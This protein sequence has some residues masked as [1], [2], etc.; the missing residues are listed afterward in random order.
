MLRNVLVNQ[1]SPPEALAGFFE[2]VRFR[3]VSGF[4]TEVHMQVIR[5]LGVPVC[6]EINYPS[7]PGEGEYER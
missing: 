2:P 6:I 1:D 5:G 7:G 4:P 3:Y